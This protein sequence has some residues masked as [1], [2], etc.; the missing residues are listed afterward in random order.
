MDQYLLLA[1]EYRWKHVVVGSYNIPEEDL[2]KFGRL[3]AQ[4]VY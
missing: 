2:Q 1:L 3:G 4:D